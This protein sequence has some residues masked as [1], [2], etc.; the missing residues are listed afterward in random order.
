MKLIKK[1]IKA[2]LVILLCLIASIFLSYFF[3][4]VDS[5]IIDYYVI[6]NIIISFFS[7]SL[8]IVAL[9][10]TVLDKYKEAAKYQNEWSKKSSKILK[11]LSE[12]TICLLILIFIL[13]IASLLEELLL[14]ITFIN[15]LNTI[16]IFTFVLSLVIMIDT[17]ISIYLLVINLKDILSNYDN[18]NFEL[19]QKEKYVVEAYRFLNAEYKDQ[20]EKQLTTLAVQQQMNKSNH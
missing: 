19:T 2:L 14:T 12:N 9:I 17:T 8:A 18:I 13:A 5:K 11:A 7:V 20:I 1:H 16:L 15:I 10:I 4:Y 3:A 6:I